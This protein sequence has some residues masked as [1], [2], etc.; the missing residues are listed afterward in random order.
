MK[1][2]STYISEQYGKRS[3]KN[4]RKKIDWYL[5]EYRDE[6]GNVYRKS[7]EF[8]MGTKYQEVIDNIPKEIK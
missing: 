3:S 8:P 5:V 2:L 4:R 7:F 6:K 1:T